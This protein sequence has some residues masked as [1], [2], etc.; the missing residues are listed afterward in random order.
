ML[1]KLALRRSSVMLWDVAMWFLAVLL[2]VLVRFDLDLSRSRI[3][4][5][6]LYAAVAAL[7]QLA[8]GL[9]VHHYLGRAKLGSFAEVAMLGSLVVL[10]GVVVGLGAIAIQPNFSRAVTVF[11]PLLALLG[12]AARQGAGPRRRPG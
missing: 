3:E 9:G 7:L 12:M 4:S 1:F 5:I 11:V 2:L 6:F 8:L 10:V